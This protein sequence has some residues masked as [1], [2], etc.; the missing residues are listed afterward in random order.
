MV[1]TYFARILVVV[2]QFIELVDRRRLR[3]LEGITD[4]LVVCLEG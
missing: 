4:L 2:E 3:R 1:R